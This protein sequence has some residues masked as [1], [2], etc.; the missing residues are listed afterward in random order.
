MFSRMVRFCGIAI[1]V[2]CVSAGCSHW[3]DI[4]SEPDVTGPPVPLRKPASVPLVIDEVKTKVNGTPDN[5]NPAFVQR[6]ASTL[7]GT[8]LFSNVYEPQVSFNAPPESA[9]L[10]LEVREDLDSCMGTNILKGF[11]IGLTYFLLT[12]ALPLRM[13]MTSTMACT[14]EISGSES[15][16]YEV[17]TT[18]SSHWHLFA[19]AALVGQELAG[20]VTNKNLE[21]LAAG[22][23]ADA[24]LL[25][26]L[27]R[28]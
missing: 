11:F 3:T 2:V 24:K 18:G 12:P 15:S 8:K 23:K 5:P 9:H 22:F 6:F 25:K 21:S 16:S 1:A 10:R 26:A 17:S 13:D 14:V 28:N 4:I 27:R 20:T 19:N 7:R